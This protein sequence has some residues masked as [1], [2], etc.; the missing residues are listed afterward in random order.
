MLDLVLFALSGR[1][2][3]NKALCTKRDIWLPM[4]QSLADMYYPN[5]G[6]FHVPDPA[7]WPVRRPRQRFTTPPP[8]L[9]AGDWQPLSTGF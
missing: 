5:R 9:R 2:R 1:S 4:W 8:C 6:G 3:R 7:S